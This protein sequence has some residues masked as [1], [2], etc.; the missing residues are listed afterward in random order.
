MS[1]MEKNDVADVDPFQ[2]NGRSKERKGLLMF[3]SG[4]GMLVM[5]PVPL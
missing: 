1:A 5:L 4:K 2:K 3:H